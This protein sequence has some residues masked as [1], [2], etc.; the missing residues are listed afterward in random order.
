MVSAKKQ[1][2]M[3]MK[4]IMAYMLMIGVASVLVPGC[5]TAEKAAEHPSGKEHP[6]AQVET[7]QPAGEH[8]EAAKAPKDHPA[9]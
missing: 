5:K 8:P 6:A 4:K 2:E 7:E 3:E 9:H 1:G